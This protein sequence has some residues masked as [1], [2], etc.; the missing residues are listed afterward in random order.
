MMIGA[1]FRSRD[2]RVWLSRNGVFLNEPPPS[3]ALKESKSA[4]AK[5]KK[6]DKKNADKEVSEADKLKS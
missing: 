4:Q 1:G 6:K 3:E 2:N 5:G